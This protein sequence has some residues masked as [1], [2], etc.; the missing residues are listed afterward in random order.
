VTTGEDPVNLAA[1]DWPDDEVL[2]PGSGAVPSGA[3]VPAPVP[4]AR[5]GVSPTVRWVAVGAV[6]V[7]AVVVGAVVVGA[8]VVGLAWLSRLPRWVRGGR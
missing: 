3:V 4:T 2:D 1:G 5:P 6:V 7:G 8:V